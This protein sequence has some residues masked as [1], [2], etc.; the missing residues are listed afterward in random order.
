V[1]FLRPA[2]DA[3]RIST[4][5][6]NDTMAYDTLSEMIFNKGIEVSER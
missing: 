1:F 6:H 4:D 3:Y 2:V 5:Y